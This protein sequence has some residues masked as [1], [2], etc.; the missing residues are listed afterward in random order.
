LTPIHAT[1]AS[2]P[3]R[4]RDV[5][6]A[7]TMLGADGRGSEAGERPRS[8]VPIGAARPLPCILWE[9]PQHKPTFGSSRGARAG[10][11]CGPSVGAPA[12]AWPVRSR[13]GKFPAWDA[14]TS[15]SRSYSAVVPTRTSASRRCAGCCG[16]DAVR[17]TA[18]PRT[19]SSRC[20][21]RR[22]QWRRRECRVYP[23]HLPH[24]AHHTH[25]V[26]P[27]PRDRDL[28]RGIRSVREGPSWPSRREGHMRRLRP[29][30]GPR[31]GEDWARA[32]CF[33]RG[34]GKPDSHKRP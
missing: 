2:P 21:D 31:P 30:R 12:P 26:V 32:V 5:A 34:E 23:M 19:W 14:M 9:R 33:C 16:H 17:A 22:S 28:R 27:E 15:C 6:R 1:P 8:V 25:R 7:I 11:L 4:S 29:V 3:S 24:G 18:A 20:R 13:W 10:R